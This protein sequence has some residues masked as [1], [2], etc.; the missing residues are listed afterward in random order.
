MSIVDVLEEGRIRLHQVDLSQVQAHD[1]KNYRRVRGRIPE[2]MVSQWLANCP[3]IH[4]DK[5]IPRRVNGYALESRVYGGV[6]VRDSYSSKLLREFD[7]L[8]WYEGKPYV[9]EVKGGEL[10]RGAQR[11]NELL[12]MGKQVYERRDVGLVVFMLFSATTMHRRRQ[13]EQQF[14]HLWF[15]DLGYPKRGMKDALKDYRRL[16]QQKQEQSAAYR[17][18]YKR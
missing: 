16:H 15:V 10:K 1:P 18:L 14:R 2:A 4:P 13:L 17:K 9:I 11:V 7:G 3:D 12:E 8:V 6:M 5:D